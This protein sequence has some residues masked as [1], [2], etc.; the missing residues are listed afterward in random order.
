MI[1][2]LIYPAILLAMVGLSLLFLLGYVVPQFAAMYE[3]LDAELPLFTQ[4][5]LWPSACSCATGGRAAGRPA[6]AV[7]WFDRKRRDPVFRGASTPGCCSASSSAPLV[8]QLETARLARTLGTLVRN[9]VPLLTALGI[10]RNVLATGCWRADVEAAA[11]EVKTGVGLV[12]RA[13]P[14]ASG[15]RG[16]RC[17]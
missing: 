12:H 16:W 6:L 1:N 13:G 3:S 15:S 17:R 14:A 7:W 11:D 4:L 9:G 10:A 5:V 2:A 8:A